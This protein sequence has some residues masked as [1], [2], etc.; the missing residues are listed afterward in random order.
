MVSSKAD[1]ND[2]DDLISSGERITEYVKSNYY[3][4]PTAT[5]AQAVQEDSDH[6]IFE[7]PT[8]LKRDDNTVARK[9]DLLSD[10]FPGDVAELV[11]TGNTVNDA[12][13][14][15]GTA[16]P[17]GGIAPYPVVPTTGT[18]DDLLTAIKQNFS[19]AGAPNYE[20][21]EV[22][23]VNGRIT[24]T[25]KTVQQT[26]TDI[27]D[28]PYDGPSYFSLNIAGDDGTGTPGVGGGTLNPVVAFSTDFS[29]ESDKVRFEK[30]GSYLNANVSQIKAHDNQY[31]DGK[32]KL[33]E[34]SSPR[35]V[36]GTYEYSLHGKTL[37]MDLVD[38]NGT[39]YHINV[40]FDNAG[41]TYNI[42]DTS[43]G[44]RYP[45]SP[46][47]PPATGNYYLFENFDSTNPTPADEVTYEQLSNIMEI[48]LNFSNL[49]ASGT[50]P[51]DTGAGVVAD[52]NAYRDAMLASQDMV[53]VSLDYKGR[54]EVY[55][56]TQNNS[57]IELA[58]YDDDNTDFSAPSADFAKLSFH[59]NNAL[60]VDDPHVDFFATVDAAIDAVRNKIYRPDGYNEEKDYDAYPRSIGIQNSI[61][62]FDHLMDHINKIH[63]KNGSQG[64]ALMSSY[65]RSEIMIV[66]A[67]TLK[68]DI[69][70]T[71][72][73]EASMQLSQLQLNYQAMLSSISKITK[74]SL[75]N[76]VQAFWLRLHQVYSIIYR[77]CS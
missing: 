15:G 21:I 41:T 4:L 2:T 59:E 50:T 9:T 45:A 70:D 32:T 39:P 73:A 76:Y 10:I 46:P 53:D 52:V 18:V 69:V 25:D 42:T 12:A 48:G 24:I 61:T 14:S 67:K 75:V 29:A 1:V 57:Q 63:A 68:S 27:Q 56:K 47:V 20:D 5:N 6:R 72:M 74:L 58:M 8:I 51:T 19:S 28:P 71:D 7:L 38:V 30:A 62:A 31:A 26:R 60:T 54:F 43:T 34:V 44:T 40:N 23:L 16:V 66:Q 35:R 3:S 22:E 65:E 13:D 37:Q 17:V 64:G 77:V 11:L 55:D 49:V 33:I 36:D